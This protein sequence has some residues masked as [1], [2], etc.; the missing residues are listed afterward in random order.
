MDLN[1]LGILHTK[2]QGEEFYIIKLIG[3]GQYSRVYLS[4]G[5]DDQHYAIK[6]FKDNDSYRNE[7]S[8]LSE[9]SPSKHI[10]KL[11]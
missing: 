11:Y 10:V 1:Y 3:E 6:I 7:T 4:L 9:L 5:K 8:R 2:K